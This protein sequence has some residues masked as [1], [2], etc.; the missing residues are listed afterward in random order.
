MMNLRKYDKTLFKDGI[1]I[2]TL[3]HTSRTYQLWVL[4][5]EYM[6]IQ[7]VGNDHLKKAL[8][9][10]FL[11]VV[12]HK[13]G[14]RYAAGISKKSMRMHMFLFQH[15]RTGKSVAVN[16]VHKLLTHMG[17]NSRKTLRDNAA[18]CVGTVVFDA[19]KMKEPFIRYGFLK[20][21]D[22]YYWDE[23][24]ILLRQN[25]GDMEY[26]T[27]IF[28]G[29]M[30]EP[31]FISKGM[32]HGEIKYDTNATICACSYMFSE[33]TGAFITKGFFQRMFI[34]YKEFDEFEKQVLRRQV[35]LLT[36][37]YNPIRVNKIMEV[38]KEILNEIPAVSSKDAPLYHDVNGTAKM[39][40][41]YDKL[42]YDLIDKQFT[43]RT[44][45]VLESFGDMAHMHVNK[46]SAIITAVEGRKV[47]SYDDMRLAIPFVKLHISSVL[48]L[49][50]FVGEEQGN[51]ME[52]RGLKIIEVM[53]RLPPAL[54]VY[55][56]VVLDKMEIEK[57]YGRWDMGRNK[58]RDLLVHLIQTKK[59]LIQEEQITTGTVTKS[60]QSLRVNK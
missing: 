58:T 55:Q 17:C 10:N 3:D 19:K 51:V 57:R 44:Q 20:D 34:L 45:E 25:G 18:S 9:F 8:F 14:Y 40:E 12:L 48:D 23:G 4:W 29:V 7:L 28:Q 11:S 39:V 5:K 31:G 47:V 16:A 59:V 49:F 26:I 1:E 15:S 56:K 42:Y 43:G 22:A 46:I 53:L 35:P 60:V 36:N 32:A 54:P 2:D 27:D 33:F 6:D 41:F 13:K 30:D 38:I 21:I 52:R 24:S 50:N 37:K